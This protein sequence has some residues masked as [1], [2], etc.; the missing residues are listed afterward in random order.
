[1]CKLVLGNLWLSCT[2]ITHQFTNSRDLAS[3]NI[4]N[5]TWKT[6]F[7]GMP[8]R[9][10]Y[11]TCI[12]SIIN[13]FWWYLHA[14]NNSNNTLQ[15][16]FLTCNIS[17]RRSIFVL[18]IRMHRISPDPRIQLFI[19]AEK[20]RWDINWAYCQLGAQHNLS[21]PLFTQHVNL[22]ANMF[23]FAWLTVTV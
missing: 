5:S 11:H 16:L 9:H 8:L 10:F 3:F 23:N 12:Q 6:C 17:T 1:M 14:R 13:S 21:F 4:P 19:Q 15:H 22:W 20:K 7:T 2:I 18:A